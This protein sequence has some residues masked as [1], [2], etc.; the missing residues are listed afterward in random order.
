MKITIVKQNDNSFKIA[1]DSDYEK[2]KKLKV[3][4]LLECEIKRKRNYKFHKLYFSLI[5]MVY[6]NQSLYTNID[7]LR[8][9]LTIEAGYYD[10]CFNFQNESVKRAKSISFANMDEDEFNELYN[11]TIDVI[12]KYFNFD[13]QLILDN[14]EQYY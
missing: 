7:H 13:K 9:D 4:E 8:N 1:F 10:L 12:V 5:N 11:R 14:I 3:G 2:A 6:D